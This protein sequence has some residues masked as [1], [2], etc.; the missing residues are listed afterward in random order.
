MVS[1]RSSRASDHTGNYNDANAALEPEAA[2]LMQT[3]GLKPVVHV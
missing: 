1:Q 3:S 2:A